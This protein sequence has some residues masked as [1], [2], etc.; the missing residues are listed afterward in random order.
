MKIENGQDRNIAA[1]VNIFKSH[2]FNGRSLFGFQFIA[3]YSYWLIYYTEFVEFLCVC[4]CLSLSFF[5][6]SFF[7]LYLVSIHQ[8]LYVCFYRHLHSAVHQKKRWNVNETNRTTSNINWY[9]IN[10]RVMRASERMN[11]FSNHSISN[12]NGN[13]HTHMNKLI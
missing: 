2:V 3:I 10:N 4:V 11:A 5:A 8:L 7:S 1:L 6:T 13:R 9:K 12:R